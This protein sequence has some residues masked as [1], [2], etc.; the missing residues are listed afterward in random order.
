MIGN[1]KAQARVAMTKADIFDLPGTL[2]RLGGDTNL[3]ADLVQLYNED[4][5][6]LLERLQ[7][8][9]EKQHSDE[10]RHAAHSLR[11]LA[12]NFGALSLTQSLLQL[13]EVAAEGRLG[14]AVPLLNKVSQESSRLQATLA[15]HLR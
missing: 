2:R 1:E 8:G 7:T 11:G 5:P 10:V 6:A 4:S 3:L 13:E 14:E 15:L 9:I 12:A